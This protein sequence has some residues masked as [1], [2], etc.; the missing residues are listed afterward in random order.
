[1]VRLRALPPA[2]SIITPKLFAEIAAIIDELNKLA[3][4]HSRARDSEWLNLDF[5]RVHL[6]VENERPIRQAADEKAAARYFGISQMMIDCYLGIWR[7][8]FRKSGFWIPECLPRVTKRFVVHVF[9][10]QG[11]RKKIFRLRI[12]FFALLIMIGNSLQNFLQVRERLRPRRQ[13][14]IPTGLVRHVG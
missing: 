10:K 1:M 13:E 2:P 9:V 11:E 6:V 14:Q 3:V 7:V 8:G 12:D 4:G 5:V